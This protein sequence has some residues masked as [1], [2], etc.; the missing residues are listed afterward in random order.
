MKNNQKLKF[1]KENYLLKDCDNEYK[2]AIHIH[3]VDKNGN[4]TYRATEKIFLGS[5][6]LQIRKSA[7]KYYRKKNDFLSK[8]SRFVNF[9]EAE[10]RKFKNYSAYSISFGLSNSNGREYIIEGD[11]EELIFSL[12]NYEKKIYENNPNV[13]F[14]NVSASDGEVF[15][16]LDD[17][18]DFFENLIFQCDE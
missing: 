4:T 15:S 10:A 13:N 17:D 11:S 14:R 9:E 7:I 18:Y 2:V 6:M 8:K 5:N 3:S 12:L 16:V 1:S